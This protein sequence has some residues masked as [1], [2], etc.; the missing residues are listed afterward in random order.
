MLSAKRPAACLFVNG[1]AEDL[2]VIDVGVENVVVPGQPQTHIV[3]VR[4]QQVCAEGLG[5]V[6]DPES[7]QF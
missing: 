3:L 5:S 4:V 7:G 6:A 1:R 2:A